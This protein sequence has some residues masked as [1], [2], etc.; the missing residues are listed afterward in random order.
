M[1]T[2]R[3]ILLT[4]ILSLV[5]LFAQAKATQVYVIPIDDEINST[6]WRMV[7]Q[8]C[9]E[10]REMNADILL[11][12]LNTYGGAVVYADSIRTALLNYPQPVIAFID[13]NAA[14]AGALISIACDS[15]Y[16]RDG[17]SIGAATVVGGDGQQMPDKYQSYMRAMMRSTAESTGRDPAIAEAMV[18]SRIE[19][20][21]LIDST[22]VL[23][24]TASEAREHGFSNGEATDIDNILKNRLHLDNYSITTRENSFWDLLIGF[25]TNPAVQ[26]ILIMII[27]GGIYFELQ[28]PGMGFPSAAALIAAVL[29]FL[30]LYIE[31]VTAPWVVL[32]FLIGLV[33]LI[34][35]IFVIPGFGV[36]GIA[37]IVLMVTG[38]FAALLDG[39][40]F[41]FDTYTDN[42]ITHAAATVFG[43]ILLGIGIIALLTWKFGYKLIPRRMALHKSMEVDKGYIGVDMQPS[44]LVGQRGRSVT[45]LRPS[46]KI[47]IGNTIYDAVSTGSFIDRDVAVKVE[48]YENAQ[49]YVAPVDKNY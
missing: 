31:G 49:L 19:I 40:S 14:S 23:T 45:V 26:A 5:H 22:R 20:P 2:A 16:M 9:R 18:D 27:I 41:S 8:G 33:L 1:S 3:N 4:I 17:G 35:E 39:F 28:S 44:R 30:P 34:L 6:T 25:F 37:G 48:R 11:V 10:A 38:L 32:M 7:Q 46:G 47:E 42:E 21:G 43:G 36:A 13:N 29:Y 24:F 12:H 15:I